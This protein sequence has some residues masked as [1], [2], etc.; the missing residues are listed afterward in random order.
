MHGL[1]SLKLKTPGRLRAF[2]MEISHDCL[3][4]TEMHPEFTYDK[5][6]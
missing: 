4:L 5:F 2:T 6:T 1:T 3:Q